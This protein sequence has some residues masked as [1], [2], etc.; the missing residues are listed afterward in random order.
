MIQKNRINSI[1][2]R[3]LTME[4][5]TARLFFIDAMRAWAI[6]M[7]LQGHFVDGLLDNVFRDNSSAFYN[8]WKYF[9]GITAP[10]FFTVS[11]FIV[12]YLLLK[13][14]QLGRSNPRIKKSLKRGLQLVFL[15]YLLRIN[16]LGLLKGQIYNATYLVDVLHIIGFSIL[17]IIGIYILTQRLKNYV[18]P[19]VLL[20]I[21]FVL[22]IIEPIYANHSFS[23]LPEFIANYFTRANGSVF[24]IIPWIGYATFGGFLSVLF[25]KYGQLKSL[26]PM[27]IKLAIIFGVVLLFVSSPIFALLFETTNI[28]LFN[29]IALNNYLF[30]RLGDVLLVFALFML[31]RN[32][33]QQR[34]ILKVGQN[35]LSIYVIHFMI[36]Y[37]SFTGLGLYRFYNHSLSPEIVIP[38]ALIFMTVCTFLALLYARHEKQLQL[39]LAQS[40]KDSKILL[41]SGLV[42]LHR[43][44]RVLKYKAFKRARFTRN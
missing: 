42:Y 23:W 1:Y 10:V 9:R 2:H 30:I 29:K 17:G 36:L 38:G 19:L 44:L 4:S 20:L 41:D 43:N 18:F 32:L 37:G 35:T 25:N 22:F 28:E 14:A 12:T 7:M 8:I 24:T 11:G 13:N 34:L 21:S 31:A 39:L 5:K 26:Y 6:L 3:S 33:W 15:G 40:L 27:A 16:L